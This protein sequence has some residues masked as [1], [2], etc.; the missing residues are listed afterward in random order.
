MLV[1]TFVFLQHNL[2][3]LKALEAHVADHSRYSRR[4]S[5]ILSPGSPEL[6]PD[7]QNRSFP[8]RRQQERMLTQ[9]SLALGVSTGPQ[10]LVSCHAMGETGW[11]LKCG[12]TLPGSL[13]DALLSK[14]GR[15]VAGHVVYHH[16]PP[17]DSQLY[18]RFVNSFS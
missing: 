10:F 7:Y 13:Y 12:C 15:V 3:K 9:V 1:L 18:N 17:A 4:S 6:A 2:K 8:L 16:L 14:V 5:F 11:L